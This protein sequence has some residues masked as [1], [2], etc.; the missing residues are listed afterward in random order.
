MRRYI[1]WG[2]PDIFAFIVTTPSHYY[3]F[4]TTFSTSV[5][6]EKRT[7]FWLLVI[8]VSLIAIHL[9][10]ISKYGDSKLLSTSIIFLSAVLFNLWKK[11]DGIRV[12][13]NKNSKVIGIGIIAFVL[14]KTSFISKFDY[15]IQ[16]SPLLSALGMSLL[17]SGVK[18]LKQYLQELILLLT[19]A[20]PFE[21][22]IPH[23]L[24]LATLTAQAAASI[25]WCLGFK[26]LHQG[27]N[28][29]LPTGSVEVSP[30]CSGVKVVARMLRIAILFLVTFPRPWIQNILFP[31]VAVGIA[32]IV[33][34]VRVAILAVLVSESK[35]SLFEFLHNSGGHLFTMTSIII[36]AFLCYFT[37]NLNGTIEATN[38]E[39]GCPKHE[40]RSP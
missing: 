9:N 15:F 2:A 37:V 21:V 16:I 4:K 6:L 18:G 10:V 19:L 36:F 22:I 25:L 29:I 24:D 33:N 35:H 12:D 39:A 34:A 23:L 31:V 32:F 3:M 8:A 40:E 17:A 7:K 26:V 1:H 38:M 14:F 11:S 5:T 30:E 28:V 20:I 13:S 27:V